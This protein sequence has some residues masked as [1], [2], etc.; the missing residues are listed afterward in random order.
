MMNQNFCRCGREH[1]WPADTQALCRCG[2]V[3]EPMTKQEFAECKQE[4]ERRLK[5]FG[6]AIARGIDT[7]GIRL[8]RD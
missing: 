6:A 2:R 8:F 4:H 3:L 1:E 5:R 7:P